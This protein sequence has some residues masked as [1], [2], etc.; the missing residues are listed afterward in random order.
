MWQNVKVEVD[1]KVFGSCYQL[2]PWP[3]VNS[4]LHLWLPPWSWNASYTNTME[5]RI[6]L[7]QD[8]SNELSGSHSCRLQVNNGSVSQ[9]SV[10]K[11]CR[12]GDRQ[13]PIQI[14][15][16]SAVWWS[17]THEDEWTHNDNR[18][19]RHQNRKDHLESTF[20]SW[21]NETT[22]KTIGKSSNKPAVQMPFQG[23][24]RHGLS[25]STRSCL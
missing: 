14:E 10:T 25:L 16:W 9:Q 5:T 7:F 24:Y 23:P 15:Q 18:S 21:R 17:S 3:M 6:E 1:R 20:T 2:G 12:S 8:R 22:N 13:W 19:F 4:C 11:W